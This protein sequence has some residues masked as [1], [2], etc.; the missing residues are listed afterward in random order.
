V[1]SGEEVVV[2]VNRW[3]E[4][5]GD[6]PIGEVDVAA[7]ESRQV[8]RVQ[9]WRAARDPGAAA[10]GLERLRS[11]AEGEDNLLPTIREACR[12]GATLGEI[13]DVF[14]ELYGTWDEERN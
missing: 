8:E 1:E 7:I 10:H 5:A 11:A 4:D 6:A 3:T 9:A 12:A 13:A 2:G 14:R